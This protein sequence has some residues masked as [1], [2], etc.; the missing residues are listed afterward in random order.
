MPFDRQ[1]VLRGASL[2]LRPLREEDFDALYAVAGDR[3]LWEQHPDPDRFRLDVFRRFFAEAIESG[4]ALVV[5]TDDGGTVIGSSRYHGYDQELSEV[6][7]GWTFLARS[8]WGGQTN[9]EL[10]SLMLTH[11]FGSVDRVL[12]LVGIDNMRSQKALAKIGARRI[13]SRIDQSG[14]ANALFEIRRADQ[15]GLA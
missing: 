13:G 7:I 12:F 10:K 8:H 9:R 6:E 1:P 4:G 15:S 11:A 14:R 3:L 2:T 5:T